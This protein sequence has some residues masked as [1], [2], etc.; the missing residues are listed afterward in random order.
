MI[1]PVMGAEAGVFRFNKKLVSD[2]KYNDLQRFTI[3]FGYGPFGK[4][5]LCWGFSARWMQ[6]D[7]ADDLTGFYE[8]L[9]LLA[10]LANVND[11][12]NTLNSARKKLN[13]CRLGKRTLSPYAE[14]VYGK[15][16]GTQAFYDHLALYHAPHEHS[17]IF[18]RFLS[19]ANVTEIYEYCKSDVL[20]GKDLTVPLRDTQV[21]NREELIPY[22]NALQALLSKYISQGSCPIMLGN[23]VHCI[24]LKLDKIAENE[25]RWHYVD[26]NDYYRYPVNQDYFRQLTTVE[27]A[28]SL[29]ESF[30][31]PRELHFMLEQPDALSHYKNHYLYIADYLYYVDFDA[32]IIAVPVEDHDKLKLELNELNSKN[33]KSI[34]LTPDQVERIITDNGGH[35]PQSNS[36]ENLIFYINLFT[37][38]QSKEFKDAC[39]AFQSEFAVDLDEKCSRQDEWGGDLLFL[40]A[41]TNN[42]EM[43]N[44][45][46]ARKV[47]VDRRVA[48]YDRGPLVQTAGF[49][50]IQ[51]AKLLISAGCNLDQID[52]D[53]GSAL[54]RSAEYG[55]IEMVKLLV[56]SGANVNIVNDKGVSCLHVAC[57]KGH[58]D[59]VAYLVPHFA[60][61]NQPDTRGITPIR[62][63]VCSGNLALF[64]LLIVHGA[65]IFEST[66]D[67]YTILDQAVV[68]GHLN[69]VEYLVKEKGFDVNA[70]NANR[71]TPL[72]LAAQK[73]QYEIA[74]FLVENHADI[75]HACVNDQ[76]ALFTAAAF[77]GERVAKYLIE[78]GAD[79]NKTNCDGGTPILV[80]AQ[81]GY[82]NIVEYLLP[83]ETD[84]NRSYA[85]RW[86]LLLTAS[87]NNRLAVV[88]CLIARGADINQTEDNGM[89]PVWKAA[90]NGH[91]D[92]VKLLVGRGAN[93]ERGPMNCT[94]IDVAR[95]MGHQDVYDF[96]LSQS[97]K[98]NKDDNESSE[99]STHPLAS[100][101]V[102]S[103]PKLT[104]VSSSYFSRFQAA[105]TT[106][107]NGIQKQKLN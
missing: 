90:A 66:K 73:D 72:F 25:Y 18:G 16:T 24:S 46:L 49:N 55:L 31:A 101:K 68:G 32:T 56:E 38:N 20:D 2:A 85:G 42:V 14:E 34:F 96:L 23:C 88:D 45:L 57:L 103:S 7:L 80:A 19:Q 59:I 77:G 107:V 75:D 106:E 67:G 27:L 47:P 39:S 44:Q 4:G 41:N 43:A 92:V 29:L 30:R 79:T 61:I 51:I 52:R 65:N 58:Y 62:N 28:E 74:K 8:R 40:S 36:D 87:G 69:I 89:T 26:L 84:I 9:V 35:R 95:L 82:M 83:Y 105:P 22:L 91:L 94:P 71:M 17:D 64:K 11:I 53:G 104:R 100:Q 78:K 99:L 70:E 97:N 37:L 86:T 93:L 21:M 3:A 13:D 98:L 81:Q 60:D 63:A 12:N 50:H 48:Y 76:T 102:T 5:G 10:N 54:L 6:A 15:I 1:Q 33:R